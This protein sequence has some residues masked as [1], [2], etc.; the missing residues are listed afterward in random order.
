M[1]KLTVF[2]FNKLN[3]SNVGTENEGDFEILYYGKSIG[4]ISIATAFDSQYVSVD[5][6]DVNF[7]LKDW[8]CF[9]TLIQ[10]TFNISDA[11]KIMVNK[12]PHAIEQYA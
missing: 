10:E 7:S 2:E 9:L 1:N 11:Q 8:I 12:Y 5:T 3:T 6:P 4:Y